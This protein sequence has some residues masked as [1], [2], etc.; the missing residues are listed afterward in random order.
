M[1][2]HAAVDMAANTQSPSFPNAN[3]PSPS[4]ETKREKR[5]VRDKTISY[6]LT[7]KGI[8][9]SDSP[10][11]GSGHPNGKPVIVVSDFGTAQ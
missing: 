9:P 7:H 1:T 2:Q 4:A 8:L 11:N 6:S 3:N 5:K 10:V